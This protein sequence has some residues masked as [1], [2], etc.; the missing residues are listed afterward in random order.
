MKLVQELSNGVKWK[1]PGVFCTSTR[2]M[3]Q[4]HDSW[5]H[6]IFIE[7]NF[8]QKFKEQMLKKKK[9]PILKTNGLSCQNVVIWSKICDADSVKI[10]KTNYPTTE[11]REIQKNSQQLKSSRK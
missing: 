3:S 7:F 10:L 4:G 2:N 9:N 5:A 6:H 1:D 8:L 11:I